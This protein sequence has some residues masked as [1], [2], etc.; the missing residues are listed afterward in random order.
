M[1]TTSSLTTP[2]TVTAGQ[3]GTG[4]GGRGRN[5]GSGRGGGRGGAQST[6]TSRVRGAASFRGATTEMNGHVFQTSE[7]QPNRVQYKKTM[8]ALE[9]Y[10]KTKLTFV[11][12][13]APLFAFTMGEPHVALPAKLAED[14]TPTAL[15]IHQ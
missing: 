3:R 15:M 4:G 9:A 2:T 1:S 7:E 12:D 5:R 11:E 14:A 6:S 8:E 13:L 10:A